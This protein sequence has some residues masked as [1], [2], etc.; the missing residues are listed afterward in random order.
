[1]LPSPG[2]AGSSAMS[3]LPPAR[4][5]IVGASGYLA[6][7]VADRLHQAGYLV[8][9]FDRVPP[10]EDRPVD[11]I[12][13]GDITR[14]DDVRRALDG[15]DAVVHLAALVRGRHEQSLERF[16]DVM[17]KGTWFVA[18]VAA[19]TGIQRL[20]S[21]SSIAALGAPLPPERPFREDDLPRLGGSDLS[22]QL[23]KWLGEEIGRAYS[24]ARGLSVVHLRPRR[25]RRG[26]RQSRSVSS[27]VPP[28]LLVQLCRSARCGA[29]SGRRAP[30]DRR[31]S[32]AVTSSSPAIRGQPTTSARPHATLG[33]FPP[34]TGS[35][36]S[37]QTSRPGPHPPE[38][39]SRSLVVLLSCLGM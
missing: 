26:R 9:G 7:F 8:R 17:V 3:V 20:V 4:V 33:T 5:V 30:R 16:A 35:I 18:D 27:R 24:Q 37:R 32:K 11:D 13:V 22:Y 34:I 28:A 2:H 25:D 1:M 36:S 29:G 31:P 23:G 14:Y 39:R 19:S 21:M 15:Q 12:V 38:G 6:G 10:P